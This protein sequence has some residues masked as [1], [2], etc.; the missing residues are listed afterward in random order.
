MKNIVLTFSL[1]LIAYAGS[2][3]AYRV[4]EQKEEAYEAA[5]TNVTL[6]RAAVGSIRLKT[7]RDCPS[8][9]FRTSDATIYIVNGAPLPFPEFFELATSY[10]DIRDEA[11]RTA[12]YVFVDNETQRVNRLAIDHFN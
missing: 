10:R 4:L 2:A 12:V 6:P 9:S 1:L 11:E 7:C 8:V 3:S 5:L